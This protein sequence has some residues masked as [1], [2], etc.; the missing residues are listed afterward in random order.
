M[1]DL[2]V[3]LKISAAGWIGKRSG[4][5]IHLR[6]H[7]LENRSDRNYLAIPQELWNARSMAIVCIFSGREEMLNEWMEWLVKVQKPRNCHLYF[8]KN[9]KDSV[10][11]KR[12]NEK[13]CQ[14]HESNVFNCI[15]VVQGAGGVDCGSG[16]V[17]L[18]KFRNISYNFNMILGKIKE[19][20]IFMTDDDVIPTLD[21][22]SRLNHGLCHRTLT[23]GA[24]SGV[25]ESHAHAGNVVAALSK[26]GWTDIP[27]LNEIQD[28]LVEIG[29]AGNGCLMVL[30]SILQKALPIRP[31]KKNGIHYGPD[32]H[33][34]ESIRNQGFCILLD[35]GLKCKHLKSRLDST[36]KVC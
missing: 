16:K 31:L 20:I 15:T 25:Y 23:V 3:A 30:N 6:R 28:N 33:I 7:N 24:I 21:T 11:N 29:F 36:P 35:G 10:F 22:L 34:C 8:V 12:F 13:V 27:L 26:E 4:Q 32:A 14:L 18:D 2:K 17:S 5:R 1:D 19:D 9:T